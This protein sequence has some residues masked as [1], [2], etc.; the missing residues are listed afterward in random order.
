MEIP[1]GQDGNGH[2]EHYHFAHGGPG[3]HKERTGSSGTHDRYYS[4]VLCGRNGSAGYICVQYTE[5]GS[6]GK[7]KMREIGADPKT[8]GQ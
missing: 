3:G 4:S 5:E 7:R 1:A 2:C 6:S 8:A